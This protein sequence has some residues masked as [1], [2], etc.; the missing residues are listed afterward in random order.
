MF[1]L[2]L[3]FLPLVNCHLWDAQRY[4]NPQWI[5]W[6][7]RNRTYHRRT[8][9]S[10]LHVRTKI[11]ILLSYDCSGYEYCNDIFESLKHVHKIIEQKIAIRKPIQVSVNVIS[12]CKEL[13]KCNDGEAIA[14]AG[15]TTFWTIKNHDKMDSKFKYPQ[16]LVKQLVPTDMEWAETDI[17]VFINADAMSGTPRMVWFPSDQTPIQPYQA[18]LTAM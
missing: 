10:H 1:P 4:D 13:E 2:F 18:D 11:P 3:F 16:A 12:Y 14:S 9:L 15:P 7:E 5:K 8:P 6:L 17:H